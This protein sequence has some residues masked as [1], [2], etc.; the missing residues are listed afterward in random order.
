MQPGVNFSA[1]DD[2]AHQ[3]GMDLFI[4]GHVHIYQRFVSTATVCQLSSLAT[5]FFDER[6]RRRLT[7]LAVAG[8]STRCACTRT[9][10]KDRRSPTTSRPIPCAFISLPHLSVAALRASGLSVGG[11][12]V[13]TLGARARVCR[14]RA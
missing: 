6:L 9:D 8:N 7:V 1:I 5:V 12:V 11:L 2:V 3:Y 4:A 10:R 14:R 13:R